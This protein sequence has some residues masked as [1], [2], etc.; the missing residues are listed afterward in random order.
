[1]LVPVSPGVKGMLFFLT[2]TPLELIAPPSSARISSDT[3]AVPDASAK[4]R[5]PIAVKNPL[6]EVDAID[7][8]TRAKAP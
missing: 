1:M 8:V 5:E 2:A 3:E 6:S 4:G 7:L